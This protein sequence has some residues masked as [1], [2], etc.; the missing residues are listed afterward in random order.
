MPSLSALVDNFND[1]AIGPN[2]GNSY[3]GASEAG[4]LAR[5]PCVAG[6]YAGYETASS[7]TMAGASIFVNVVNVPAASTATD[8]YCGVLVNSATAGTRLGFRINAVTG[9]LRMQN[10]VGN[11]DAAA[12][13]IPYDPVAHAFL[14]LSEDGISVYWDTSPDGTTWTNRRTLASPAWIAADASQCWVDMSAHRDVGASDYATYD[15]FNTLNNGAVVAGAAA[16]TALAGM[17]ADALATAVAGV[18]LTV[19]SGLTAAPVVSA[20]GAAALAAE[21]E[22]TADAFKTSVPEEV[23]GL[24]AGDVDLFIEQGATYNQTFTSSNADGTPF[25]WAGW[26]ARA[27]IRTSQLATAELLLDLASYLTVAGNVIGLSIPAVQT[28][29][30]TRNGRWD[31][32]LVNGPTVIRL[33]QG[34]VKVSLEVTR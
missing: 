6:A 34:D 16:L 24:T 28:K 5:V 15:L 20:R 27:Q 29:A 3:G 30:L 14:K 33:L 1:N 25:S 13:E 21:S 23:L 8:A 2:W 26:T 17:T 11:F 10:D 7:W 22:I 12:V 32:E 4:G 31:L 18:S 9:M 19:E